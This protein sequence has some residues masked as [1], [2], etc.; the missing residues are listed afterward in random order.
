MNLKEMAPLVWAWWLV[1]VIPAWG[2]G[3]ARQAQAGEFP[4]APVKSALQSEAWS[5]KNKR[6]GWG[7]SPVGRTLAEG[8]G[9][10]PQLV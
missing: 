7:F 10:E 3:C 4:H 9:P 8:P 2:G 6:K 1:H 5:Y